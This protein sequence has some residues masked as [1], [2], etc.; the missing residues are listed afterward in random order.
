MK[1]DEIRKLDK[2]KIISEIKEKRVELANKR[3]EKYIGKEKNTSSFKS[4]K[5]EIARFLTI[6][7]EK[8]ALK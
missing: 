5:K 8:E 4:L 2:A 1:V 3:M 6:L 7:N